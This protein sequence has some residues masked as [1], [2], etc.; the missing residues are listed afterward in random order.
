M[1]ALRKTRLALWLLAA[2]VAFILRTGLEP[3]VVGL[4][5]PAAC[6]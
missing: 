4:F 5:K 6:A 3:V 2:V 1:P